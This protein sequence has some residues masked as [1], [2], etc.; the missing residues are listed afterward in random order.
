[1]LQ[2]GLLE[3]LRL[4]ALYFH[5][6]CTFDS[7]AFPL[8]HSPRPSFAPIIVWYPLFFCALPR[9]FQGGP[10]EEAPVSNAVGSARLHSRNAESRLDRRTQSPQ[11]PLLQTILRYATTTAAAAATSCVAATA[12]RGS[13]SRVV[14]DLFFDITNF[15]RRNGDRF[16][17]RL[18]I[19][20]H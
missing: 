19:L 20:C 14:M 9:R 10:R 8:W 18:W 12:V 6:N 15:L 1:M 2:G 17:W 7:A 5:C 3:I 16:F 11:V 13:A 4:L